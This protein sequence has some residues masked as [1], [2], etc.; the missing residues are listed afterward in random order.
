MIINNPEEMKTKLFEI[1]K[2]YQDYSNGEIIRYNGK[3]KIKEES[4][5]EHSFMVAVNIIKVCKVLNIPDNIRDRAV[6]MGV[7][8][9]IS[10]KYVGDIA[11]EFKSDKRNKELLEEMFDNYEEM[12]YNSKYQQEYGSIYKD[13]YDGNNSVPDRLV[14]LGDSMSVIQYSE[15]EMALGN[16]TREMREIHTSAANRFRYD[17]DRLIKSIQEEDANE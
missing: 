9:D 1:S 13:V 7:L 5:A 11:Y 16:K 10:E 3:H 12:L 6:T 4:I 8:H 17:Y 15:R 14:K 2:D